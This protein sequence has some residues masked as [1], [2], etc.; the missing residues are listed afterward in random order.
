MRS[1][2][3]EDGVVVVVVVVDEATEAWPTPEVTGEAADID[4]VEGNRVI[5]AL[6]L[7]AFNGSLS[8]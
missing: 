6:I 7:D 8:C 4:D 5:K 2:F 1:E 3:S